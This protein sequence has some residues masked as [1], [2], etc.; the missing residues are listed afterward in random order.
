MGALENLTCPPYDAVSSD[1][2][3]IY[4]EKDQYNMINLEL[5]EGENAYKNAAELLS[6]WKQD[7]VLEKDKEDAIYL[8]E[9][10]FA[11]ETATRKIR[12]LIC[13]VKLDDAE[14]YTILPHEKTMP[15]TKQ[16]RFKLMKAA[17]CNFSPIY[18]L[19]KDP[20]QNVSKITADIYDKA[21]PIIET[22]DACGVIHRVWAITDT[23]LIEEIAKN[24][25]D[26]NLYIADGHHRYLTALKYRDWKQKKEKPEGEAPEDYVMMMLADAQ[27][28]DLLVFPTYRLIKNIEGFDKA[29][30][31]CECEKYF[32]IKMIDGVNSMR[33]TL[34]LYAKQGK[35]VFGFYA[36]HDRWAL[37]LLKDPKALESVLPEES[38]LLRSLD[39]N[40]LHALVLENT[41]GVDKD[42]LYKQNH[43]DYTRDF[44]EAIAEVDNGNAQCCFVLNPTKIDEI[45]AVA[46]AG[47]T[48][49]QRSTYFYPKVLTGLLLNELYE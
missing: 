16:D 8:Y 21:D 47:E 36:G 18:S 28:R 24:F 5:P 20:T 42:H 39:V 34:K 2:R 6:A 49:P 9:Q 43:V 31:L 22:T 44:S 12:G 25:A 37:L 3:S 19:Y 15:K 32:T 26:K 41:L 13:C 29:K 38:A 10:E 23:A 27:Q 14:S 45:L 4:V 40:I 33:S 1:E 35:K 46:D 17:S 7:G 48:M 30:I 11:F